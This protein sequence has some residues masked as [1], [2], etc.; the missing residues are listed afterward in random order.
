[1]NTPNSQIYI[2]TPR[3]DSVFSLLNSYLDINFEV[4]RKADISKYANGNDIR[5]A[6]SSTVALFS[7]FNRQLAVESIWK[8]LVMP[9]LFL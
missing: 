8:I 7:I 5:L 3:R 2:K 4:I 9:T 1:M 6:N